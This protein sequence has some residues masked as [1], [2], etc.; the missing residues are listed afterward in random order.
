VVGLDGWL[1]AL[2]RVRLKTRIL[3]V[4]NA[5][6]VGG[7]GLTMPFA[8]GTFD[9]VTCNLGINNFH[10]PRGVLAECARV[11]RPGGLLVLTT[12]LRAH[13]WSFY[14]VFAQTLHEY[15]RPDLVE[16]L[17][18]HIEHRTTVD[19]TRTML[20][21]AGFRLTRLH[22]QIFPLRYLDGSAFLR[23]PF[24]RMVFME[25]WRALLPLADEQVVF[26]RLEENLNLLAAR[27]GELCLRVPMAYM[28]AELAG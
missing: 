8:A 17:R 2:D 25:S 20:E 14:G 4:P 28:E 11:L 27:E 5:V 21:E 19:E 3:G 1:Y 22:E 6:P 24:V 10:D 16:R 13:M 15:G 7:D 23:H 9:V 18:N 26:A 12:N